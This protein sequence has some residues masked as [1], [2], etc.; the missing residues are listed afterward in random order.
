[1]QAAEEPSI[2]RNRPGMSAFGSQKR[3]RA[4]GVPTAEAEGRSPDFLEPVSSSV[5]WG[6]ERLDDERDTQ[7]PAQCLVGQG[8]WGPRDLPPVGWEQRLLGVRAQSASPDHVGTRDCRL[9]QT[10]ISGNAASPDL[11]GAAGSAVM[12][13]ACRAQ[14]I[15]PHRVHCVQVPINCNKPQWAP[16]NRCLIKHLSPSQ[17]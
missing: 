4:T 8:S 2:G 5:H 10:L 3:A 13:T 16:N 15:P 12:P 9:G 6:Q 1:M 17:A 11:L 14:P 7:H